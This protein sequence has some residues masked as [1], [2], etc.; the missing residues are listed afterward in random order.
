[1]MTRVGIVRTALVGAVAVGLVGALL[2][3]RPGLLPVALAWRGGSCLGVGMDATLAGS[4]SDP[5]LTWATIGSSGVR[6]DLVWPAG[7]Q[8]RFNPSLE[9]LDAS[10]MIV[11][12]AG[13]LLIG[14]C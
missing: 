11:A 13:D 4:A 8:D 5:R 7:Y 2:L 3:D 14:R 10:G 12:H 6:V 9:L 1:M